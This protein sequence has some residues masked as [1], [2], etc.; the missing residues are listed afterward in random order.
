MLKH[1]SRVW[2]LELGDGNNKFFYISLMAR[3]NRN[4]ITRIKKENGNV[5]EVEG[6]IKEEAENHFKRILAPRI[7]TL[8]DMHNWQP[9][10]TLS[11][12]QRSMLS[13]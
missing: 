9:D 5:V 4:Q 8:D 3:R 11:E 1:K 7:I 12:E 6:M 2:W 10:R 13:K